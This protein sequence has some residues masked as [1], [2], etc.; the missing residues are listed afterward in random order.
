[1]PRCTICNR[2]YVGSYCSFCQDKRKNDT[3]SLDKMGWDRTNDIVFNPEN[4][5][6]QKIEIHGNYIQGNVENKTIHG[7]E[8]HKGGSKV[9]EGAFVY[10]S[11]LGGTGITQENICRHCG[12]D[13]QSSWKFCPNCTN[14][15]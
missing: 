1:M 4:I 5:K 6:S 15:L 12:S 7:D 13:I 3:P 8:I 2:M 14:Q 11:Q 9:G 10:K